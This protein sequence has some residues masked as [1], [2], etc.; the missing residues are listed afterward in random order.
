MANTLTPAQL[1]RAIDACADEITILSLDCFDTLL[2]RS[3]HAPADLF[4][5]LHCGARSR[6]WSESLQREFNRIAR[7]LLTRSRS[8]RF[9]LEP[10]RR[11]P[12]G[13]ES[14]NSGGAARR[15]QPLLWFAGRRTA[16]IRKAKQRGLRSSL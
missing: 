8:R 6:T 13:T 1:A 16:L 2:W 9:M 12:G 5:E 15:A 7:K 11:R 3:T 10:I 14:A 4:S